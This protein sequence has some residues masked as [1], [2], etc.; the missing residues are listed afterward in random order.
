MRKK[1]RW[2]QTLPRG[3]PHSG[4]AKDKTGSSLTATS[5]PWLACIVGACSSTGF[6]LRAIRRFVFVSRGTHSC[7]QRPHLKPQTVIFTFGMRQYRR[8]KYIIRK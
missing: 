1:A 4:K 3:P 7:S 6:A 8:G 5:P 2:V